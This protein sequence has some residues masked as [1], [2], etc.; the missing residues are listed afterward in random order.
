MPTHKSPHCGAGRSRFP[1]FLTF[2]ILNLRPGDHFFPA[3][4]HCPAMSENRVPR[5]DHVQMHHQER[6]DSKGSRQVNRRNDV[7][8]HQ[9]KAPIEESGHHLDG[10]E[11]SCQGQVYQALERFVLGIPAPGSSRAPRPGPGPKTAEPTRHRCRPSRPIRRKS[12]TRAWKTPKDPCGGAR[13][14]NVNTLNSGFPIML[15]R[16]MAEEIWAPWMSSS[17]PMSRLSAQALQTWI[18]HLR[19]RSLSSMSF[20]CSPVVER[21]PSA[22]PSWAQWMAS[23]MRKTSTGCPWSPAMAANC[24]ARVAPPAFSKP[25][26]ITN[27]SLCTESSFGLG[28]SGN[29]NCGTRLH[30]SEARRQKNTRLSQWQVVCH[31]TGMAGC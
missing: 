20:M 14:Q 21:I 30:L 1:P 17:G 18:G 10:K 4:D 5:C 9:A 6:E 7:E 3:C 24:I 29:S 25:L 31:G 15:T 2:P 27:S 28:Q 22:I 11:G 12:D 19:L 23:S 16:S 13:H 8:G 26:E